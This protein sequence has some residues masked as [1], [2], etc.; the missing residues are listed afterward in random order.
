MTDVVAEATTPTD[1]EEFGTLIREYEAWLHERYADVPGL[2]DG[3][4]A[5]QDLDA[6]L[7]ALPEK[8]GPPAGRTL[9]ARRG[10]QVTGCVAYR[11]LHDGS[12][13]MKRLFVPARFNGH[14]TG[15][16]LCE[17]LIAAAAADGYRHMRLD[18][19]FLNSEAM[20]M[21][22]TLGFRECPPYSDYPDDLGAH[23]RFMERDLG[24]DGQPGLRSPVSNR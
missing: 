11:D 21:Y 17:A 1:F 2:I 18:T 22:A 20:A 7:A 15:R 4:R 10:E 3:V 13:E 6:E 24:D 16:L 14:G 12:C 19:G 8:Y 9:L 23:L 5:H